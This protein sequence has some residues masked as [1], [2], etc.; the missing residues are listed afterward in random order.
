LWAKD[1]FPKLSFELAA[2]RAQKICKTLTTSA[3]LSKQGPLDMPARG[4]RSKQIMG[5]LNISHVVRQRRINE[6]KTEGKSP[7]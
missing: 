7:P 1:Y 5:K 4:G 6:D 3:Y 2:E